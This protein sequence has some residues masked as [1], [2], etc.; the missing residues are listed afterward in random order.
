MAD[1]KSSNTWD[2]WLH[3][4]SGVTGVLLTQVIK[5]LQS[6]TLLANSLCYCPPMTKSVKIFQKI[7]VLYC[8]SYY[9]ISPYFG[10]RFAISHQWDILQLVAYNRCFFK[11]HTPQFTIKSCLMLNCF[12]RLSLYLTENTA[13]LNYENYVWPQIIPYKENSLSQLW[14]PIRH[15]FM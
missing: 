4:N 7:I 12:L 14:K 1:F 6:I 3:F 11:A 13:C 5:C 15:I 9:K 8:N 2:W 10:N